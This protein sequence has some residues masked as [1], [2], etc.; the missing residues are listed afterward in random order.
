VQK[1]KSRS[2]SNAWKNSACE[3]STNGV[4]ASKGLW[5]SRILLDPKQS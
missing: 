4:A 3:P 5:E 1:M 2:A